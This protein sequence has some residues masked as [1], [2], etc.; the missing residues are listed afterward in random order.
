MVLGLNK[1]LLVMV[2][3]STR[4]TLLGLLLLCFQG[5]A[6]NKYLIL[7]K[8]KNNSPFS[9]TKPEEFLSTR[10]IERR[11][12]QKIK[13]INRDLPVNPAYVT[14]ISKLGVKVCYKSKWLNGVLVETSPQKL[15]QILKLS[16]VKGLEGKGDIRNAKIGSSAGIYKDKFAAETEETLSYGN[17]LT[18]IEMLKANKM[19]EAGF[20][21]EG[22]LIGVFDSGF[23]NAD[24]VPSITHLFTNKRI[25]KTFDFVANNA[26]VY[27]DHNHGLRVLTCMA[28]KQDGQLIGTAPEASYA[29]FRT[30]DVASE[31][32]IEEANWLF[33]AEMADSLGVD[34]VN[35]SLGYYYFDAEV[36][37]YAK[38]DLAGNKTLVTRA[39]DWLAST[40]V[41]ICNSA[42]NE[43]N[44]PSW[45]YIIA[46]ADADSVLAVAAVDS[47]GLKA[48]FSSPGPRV[49]GVVKPDLAAMGQATVL[50]HENGAVTT[51]NGTSFSSPLM[52]GFAAGF[53]QANRN[54]TNMEV[55]AYLKRSASQYNQPDGALGY[56][57]PNFEKAQE[58]VAFDKM[59]KSFEGAG[60]EIAIFSNPFK[61][62]Q[63]MKVLI[64][65]T[66]K[67][68]APYD[69]QLIN[70]EGIVVS[71][72]SS[73]KRLF[74]IVSEMELPTAN[75]FLKVQS[76]TLNQTIRVLKL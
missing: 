22:M 38:S 27:E 48:S 2:K 16:F 13:L 32:R 76:K 19:H 50:S 53:W 24:K 67:N 60:Q 74:G 28:G 49:D 9:L 18:Q 12:K 64:V 54:L 37:N 11:T 34:V 57:I 46:P 39:A 70:N 69:W 56:G 68:P 30:E 55:M 40:G 7:L 73:D 58:E 71:K 65:D 43:G 21:G 26:S 20:K 36:Q 52:A 35:S 23:R 5:V 1:H 31:T 3:N 47:R 33:A 8:D 51:S 75:Y 44:D 41:L 63:D 17:S 4:I 59:L 29:L 62:L 45:N 61:Q 25:V 42:G 72:G 6:Q 15:E 66:Q 10:S 14:E